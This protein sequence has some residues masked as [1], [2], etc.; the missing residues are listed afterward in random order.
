MSSNASYVIEYVA[1][2]RMC[3]N[4]SDVV[5]RCYRGCATIAALF[6]A[7]DVCAMVV[8]TYRSLLDAE[9]VM[10]AEKYYRK[11][12]DKSTM[13]YC[14]LSV[15]TLSLL[16]PTYMEIRFSTDSFFMNLFVLASAC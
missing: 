10:I 1:C 8:R 3:S 11:A 7:P 6:E 4:M 16:C 5:D 2:R 13:P 9:Y 15:L 14:Y 12:N